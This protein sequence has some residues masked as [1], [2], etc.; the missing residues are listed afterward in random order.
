VRKVVVVSPDRGWRGAFEAEA[1]RLRSILGE[2][3]V[4]IHHIGSTAIPGIAAKPIIDILPVVRKI[5]RQEEMTASG[6]QAWGE[7]GLPG[8]RYFT[9]EE[10]GKRTHN[11]HA[12]AVGNP[13]ST[14]HLA[15]R[16]YMN[17]H[18][19][20][21]HAYGRLKEKLAQG[22]PTDFEAYMDGKHAFVQ[23]SERRALAWERETGR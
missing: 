21:A 20:V 3:L 2:N 10:N 7:F 1:A 14:R 16:D 8:R 15:F 5:E 18:P 23:E 17:A 4:Q 22:F 6:Y 11:V 13:E 12:Y 9:R 19:E